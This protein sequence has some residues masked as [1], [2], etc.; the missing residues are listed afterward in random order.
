MV[1]WQKVNLIN[2]FSFNSVLAK[3]YFEVL[4]KQSS[5]M[6]VLSFYR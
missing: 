5:E 4:C 3:K 6:L 2:K 1:Q